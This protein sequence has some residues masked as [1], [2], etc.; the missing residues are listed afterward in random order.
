V[1]SA[2]VS[3]AFEGKIDNWGPFGLLDATHVVQGSSF[4][5]THDLNQEVDF[6]AGHQVTGAYL[7]LDFT[8]DAVALLSLLRLD[9]LSV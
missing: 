5:Y 8:N 9:R 3:Y 7:E 1:K 4:G 6:A 2:G